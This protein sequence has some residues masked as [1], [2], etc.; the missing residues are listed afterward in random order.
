M[1][2]E[3][4]KFLEEKPGVKSFTRLNIAWYFWTICVP[5]SLWVLYVLGEMALNKDLTVTDG[6]TLAGIFIILQLAWI[7]PKQLS[8]INEIKHLISSSK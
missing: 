6:G 1:E 5:G 4:V 2:T 7:A 3:K 8:K